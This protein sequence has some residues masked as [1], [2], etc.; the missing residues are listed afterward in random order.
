MKHDDVIR[1][2]LSPEFID[3][4]AFGMVRALQNDG[5]LAYLVGGCVRDLLVGQTPKDFDIGTSATPQQ[6][7]RIISYSFIIG[8]RFR[9]VLAKRGERQYEIATFRREPLPDEFPEGV[10]FGDNIFGTPEQDA[11]RRDF[12][13]NALFYDP[14]TNEIIDHVKG[15]ED[16]EKHIVRMIGDPHIRLAE[17]PIR[18]L[19]ALRLSHKLHFR[20]ESELR[21][22]MSEFSNTLPLAVLP[23]R[24]EEFLK[25]LRLD[26]PARAFKEGYDLGV[27]TFMAPNFNKAF[28]TDEGLDALDNS[29]HR[30]KT[31]LVDSTDTCLLAGSLVLGWIRGQLKSNLGHVFT[32]QEVHKIPNLHHL[33]KDELGLHNWEISK[34]TRALGMMRTLQDPET[35]K[36]KGARRRQSFLMNEGFGLALD[37]AHLDAVLDPEVLDYWDSEYAGVQELIRSQPPAPK[38]FARG[39]K[40]RS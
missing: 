40:R 23:R 11:F 31:R 30:L 24:R 21:Q 36:R 12:T 26:D 18:I 3:Y 33:Y 14:V 22:K 32:A 28:E 7:K 35:F 13:L 39:R 1:P 8:K 34:L 4:H 38:R 9:L 29:L 2:R 17:D 37:L 10:P 16:I 25:I 15:Q 5:Y 27:W 19:R 6:V 20:I